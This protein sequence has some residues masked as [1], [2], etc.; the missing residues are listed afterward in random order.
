[1]VSQQSV[2][3]A[4]LEAGVNLSNARPHTQHDV[5]DF[6][7]QLPT[8]KYVHY[9]AVSETVVKTETS[10]LQTVLEELVSWLAAS[11]IH[12]NINDK[13]TK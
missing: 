11:H 5:D 3:D 2:I 4:R 12:V 7:L 1:M 13:K 6:G 10:Q 9:T 8:D